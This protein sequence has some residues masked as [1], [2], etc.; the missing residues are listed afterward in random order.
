MDENDAE[1]DD[2]LTKNVRNTNNQKVNMPRR[3]PRRVSKSHP[4]A[5]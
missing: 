4:S 3:N 5:V 2:S 1:V